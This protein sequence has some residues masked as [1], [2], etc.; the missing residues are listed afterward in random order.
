MG[1]DH[2][3]PLGVPGGHVGKRL[4]DD[5][6]LHAELSYCVPLALPHSQFKSWDE[7]D[8]DKALA[9]MDDKSYRC[10]GC[11]TRPDDWD[12]DPDAYIADV[13]VCKGCE[14]L[15]MERQNDV[16]KRSGAKVGLVPRAEAIAKVEQYAEP[17]GKRRER[18]S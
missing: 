15:E 10:G 18:N 5:P 1:G 13:V 16:A 8:Q 4:R 17:G 11:G 14:R 2:G 6:Q 7:D 12:D 3:R 9:Y